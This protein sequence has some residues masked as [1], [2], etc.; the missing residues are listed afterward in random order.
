MI[1]RVADVIRTS[2]A[3]AAAIALTAVSASAQQKGADEAA[4]AKVRTAY[5]AA[6][7]S[8]DAA[9]LAK[10]FAPDGIEMPPNV[11]AVKG[12]AAIEAFHKG[13]AKQWM[14]HG[15]TIT[16]T[17]LKVSG[18]IAHDV[19]TYKQQM[20]SNANGAVVDDSGKYVV[21]L[22]KRDGGWVVTHAIYSSDLPPPAPKK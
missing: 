22:A 4:I 10:V 9:A 12:R 18:N 20:M 7:L 5:Q 21:L 3:M 2:A 6:T 17:D 1:S 13:L 16:S 8:Q 11:P 14:M 15:V 19:G